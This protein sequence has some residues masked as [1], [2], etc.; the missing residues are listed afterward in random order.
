MAHIFRTL[1]PFLKKWT[2]VPDNYDEIYQQALRE[3]QQPDFEA[4]G[5]LL[6]IWG[7]IPRRND[8]PQFLIVP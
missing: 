2:Q 5:T 6:T 8:D 7:T 4:T 3:M 1:R